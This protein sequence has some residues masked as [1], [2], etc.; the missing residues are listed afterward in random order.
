MRCSKCKG[1]VSMFDEYQP[2]WCKE[3][4][5]PQGQPEPEEIRKEREEILAN[6]LSKNVDNRIKLMYNT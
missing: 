6:L 1:C 2:H 5:C 4:K 3:T